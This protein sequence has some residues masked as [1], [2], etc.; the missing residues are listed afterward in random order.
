MALKKKYLTTALLSSLALPGTVLAMHNYDHTRYQSE[1][2]PTFIMVQASDEAI[3]GAQ[4]F[5]ETVSARGLKF[6]SAPQLSQ[7]QRE[8]E[9]ETLLKDSFDLKTIARFAMGR[10]WRQATEEQKQEYINLFEDMVVDTYARRFGEYQ[11]Q[12]IAIE[13]A[14]AE[15]QKDAIVNSKIISNNGDPDV[16][17]DWRVRYKNGEY[18]IIDV[19]VE[20]VSMS[21]TQRSEFSSIIQSGGGNIEALLEKLRTR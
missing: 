21:L 2:L 17:L 6:L 18:R 20:G 12:Q 7:E 11:G 8:K 9:F 19:L 13:H 3:Q 15:G 5:I 14:R 10:Y 4:T 16:R 1:P